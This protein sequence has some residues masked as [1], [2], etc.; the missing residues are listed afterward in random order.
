MRKVLPIILVIAVLCG[1]IYAWRA[2]RGPERARPSGPILTVTFLDAG[3]G[4]GIVA[5]TP[6]GEVAVVD[7]GPEST[8]ADL[9]D[10][11]HG[12]DAEGLTVIVTNPSPDRA[13]ALRKLLESVSVKRIVRGEMD[14]DSRDWAVALEEARRREVPELVLSAGDGIGISRKVRFEVL[15]PPKD[16][17]DD[18]DQ[19]SPSNSM[20]SRLVFGRVRI[21]LASDAGVET[22][23]HLIR[24]K[25]DVRSDVLAVG[26]HGASDATSLEFVSFVRPRYFVVTAGGRLGRPDRALLARIGSGN[27]GGEV[28]RTDREGRIALITD[29]RTI[30]VETERGGRE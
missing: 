25:A 16:L 21:L 28:Y 11:L 8:A 10:Y 13:G 27:T 22:E 24:S 23:G 12:Q 15:S 3:L 7:P 29:G 14:S 30:A 4:G 17:I 26:R 6:D 1:A 20:V 18:K 5:Q 19:S 9:V 2:T